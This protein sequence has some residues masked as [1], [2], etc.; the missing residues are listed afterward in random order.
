MGKTKV[1][2]QEAD[3]EQI[4]SFVQTNLSKWIEKAEIEYSRLGWERG[5]LGGAAFVSWNHF[6]QEHVY[7][8]KPARKEVV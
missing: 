8:S 4:D 5:V 2:L 1:V 6:E 3:L 7:R